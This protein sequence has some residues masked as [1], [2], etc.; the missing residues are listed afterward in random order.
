MGG[1]EMSAES[2]MMT[3][4][5]LIAL[6]SGGI[7]PCVS[8]HVGDQFGKTN[9]HWLTKVFGWFYI[10]IN[11][12][13]ALFT[14]A[15]PLLLEWYGPHWAFG[16][17]GVLM[18]IATVLFWMGRNVFVHIPPRGKAFVRETFS[19]EGILTI[20]KLFV[21]FIFVAVFWLSSI[22]LIIL[23]PSGRRLDRNWLGIEWLPSQIQ[24]VNPVMIVTLVPFFSYVIYPA[25]DKIFPLTA[26]RKIAID[27]S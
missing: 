20:L 4:L 26:L 21:I 9:S 10:S 13:A 25:I 3:G 24:A 22:R 5:Y 6:G 7:K 19:A 23:G 18:A 16:I 2:W 12:G 15:T 14:L 8:A 11:V 17:P 27:S 1:P